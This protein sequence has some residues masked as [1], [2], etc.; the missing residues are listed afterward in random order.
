[1]TDD[2]T[3]QVG[4]LR[5]TTEA[6]DQMAQAIEEVSRG[7]QNEARSVA[8]AAEITARITEEINLVA[9]SARAGAT[10]TTQA[11]EVARGGAQT[12]AQNLSRMESIKSSALR[13]QAKVD[14][15]GQRS[16]QITSILE[17]IE[18]IASQTNLLA[19]NAA[20]E[21]ARAGEHGKGFAVVADEVRKLA[22][23]AAKATK[24]IGG[25]ITGI[26]ETVQETVVAIKEEADEVEAGA[27]HSQEAA[28]ALSQIVETVDAIRRQMDEISA[29]TQKISEATDT[30]TGAMLSVSAVVQENTAAS[31]EM[32][33]RSAE[34]NGAIR[35]YM[36]LSEQNRASLEEVNAAAQHV[37]EQETDVA[38]AIEQMSDLATIL[39]QQVLKLATAKISGKV[40]RGNALLGRI[41]YVREKFGARELDRVLRG[42][43]PADQ[44]ILRG[45][46]DPAG[47]YP[48]ELLGALTK[49]IRMELAGG[50]DD[51]LRDMTRFRAK[52]DIQPGAP[53]AQH[54]K[55]GDPGHIVDRMDLCLRHNWGEGVV[56]RNEYL[57]PRHVRMEVDMGRKQPRE[58]C[59]YNH[60]GWMEGVIDASGGVPQIRKTRCMHDGADFCEYD[61][62]WEMAGT[63]PATPVRPAAAT[64]GQGRRRDAA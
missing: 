27:A 33:A 20:I 8:E 19:L 6:I 47:S 16:G 53:L 43:E 55:R 64:I 14:L 23:A 21:A 44:Q 24:E 17:T 26:Q 63:G 25:L 61:I 35:S 62:R 57:G 31:E 1:V 18:G 28:G 59:T 12:I 15:M 22:E 39:Q 34:V 42:M 54:F 52:F 5:S 50:N 10:G 4:Q 56:V 7:A 9:S 58:R 48:P 32:A 30:L 46:I 45:R 36:E 2:T 41:D 49:A 40:S 51:I 38:D 13:V 11:V 37:S 29:A 3:R 60:V